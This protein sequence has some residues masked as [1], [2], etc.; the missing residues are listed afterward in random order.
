MILNLILDI[1]TKQNQTTIKDI[2]GQRQKV[3]Y[4]LLDN[5]VL[6]QTDLLLSVPQ[7]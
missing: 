1:K 4:I 2:R 5:Q 6:L 3:D 7:L